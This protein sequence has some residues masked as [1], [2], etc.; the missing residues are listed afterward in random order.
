MKLGFSY[1]SFARLIINNSRVKLINIENELALKN[2]LK[3]TAYG[4]KIYISM[5]AGSISSWM[6]NLINN[7]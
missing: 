2:F 1:N 5:G 6:K 4:E 3:Q 7:I